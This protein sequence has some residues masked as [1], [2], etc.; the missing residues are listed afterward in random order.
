MV[1]VFEI[2]K[3]F[4]SSKRETETG[5]HFVLPEERIISRYRYCLGIRC[6]LFSRGEPARCNQGRK[7]YGQS[8]ELESCF[9]E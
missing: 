6:G 9:E 1:V 7:G 3:W 4:V 2:G 5:S 8:W